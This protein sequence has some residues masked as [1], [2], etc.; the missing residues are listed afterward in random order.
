MVIQVG[1]MTTDKYHPVKPIVSKTDFVFMFLLLRDLTSTST[2]V[3]SSLVPHNVYSNLVDRSYS[4]SN[5]ISL[6][7]VVAEERVMRGQ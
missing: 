2:S 7:A 5:Y 3:P 4:A 1:L 6:I